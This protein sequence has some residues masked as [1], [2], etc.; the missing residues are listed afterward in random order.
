MRSSLPLSQDHPRARD[1]HQAHAARHGT[2][3]PKRNT[4]PTQAQN[5]AR[6]GGARARRGRTPTHPPTV[7]PRLRPPRTPR[8]VPAP[9]RAPQAP[10]ARARGD[11]KRFATAGSSRGGA[12]SS[13]PFAETP[14]AESAPPRFVASPAPHPDHPAPPAPL[15]SRCRLPLDIYVLE[16]ATLR[17][18]PAFPRRAAPPPRSLRFAERGGGA[19]RPREKIRLLRAIGHQREDEPEPPS[20]DDGI[21]AERKASRTSSR[22]SRHCA[23]TRYAGTRPDETNLRTVRSLT[24]SARAHSD[25]DSKD[26]ACIINHLPYGDI[27]ARY[28]AVPLENLQI[29]NPAVIPRQGLQYRLC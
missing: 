17:P 7:R 21:T 24:P 27:C 6:V 18:R 11:F 4:V 2:P 5:S 29:N 26:L 16:R 19:A 13:Y 8:A 12:W 22:S 1:T 28:R 25:K 14:R 9:A 23:P 20:T 3:C 15:P 10:P